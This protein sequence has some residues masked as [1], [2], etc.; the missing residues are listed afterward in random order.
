[1][2]SSVTGGKT[3]KRK[4]SN[5]HH[6]KP[7]KKQRVEEESSRQLSDAELLDTL[8]VP[9]DQMLSSQFRYPECQNIVSNVEWRVTINLQRIPET[10]A[11]P[12]YTPKK[13]AAP[14]VRIARPATTALIF[15]NGKVVCV[16]AT[17]QESARLACQKH[18]R[19]ISRLGYRTQFKVFQI[20]NRVYTARVDHPISLIEISKN[21]ELLEEGNQLASQWQPGQFPG[22]IYEMRDPVVKLTIF[23]SGKVNM[24]GVK[25]PEDAIKVWNRIHPVL[26][27]LRDDNRP[28]QSDNRYAYRMTKKLS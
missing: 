16:G 20:Q 2:D 23:D 28:V 7:T 3:R 13:F 14:R 12:E 21:S 8:R 25:P 10:Y 22:L 27:N 26:T 18:R 19:M 5:V 24:T 17:T 9:L 11:C 6:P 15:K 4:R 1:M